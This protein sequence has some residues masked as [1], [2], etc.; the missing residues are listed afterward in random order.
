MAH[1][2]FA[3][4]GASVTGR[5][6]RNVNLHRNGQDGFTIV[7]SERSTVAVVADG[8][9]SSRHSEVGAKLG[10]RLAAEI[11]RH[12]TAEHGEII[13]SAVLRELLAGIGALTAQMGGSFSRTVQDY[14]LFTL[15]GTV[16]TGETAIFFALGDGIVIV[17]G[18]HFP[19][20]PFPG[21]QPPYAAYGLVKDRVD[22]PAELLDF[23]EICRLPLSDLEHFLIG[24]DGVND[25][26]AAENL[27]TPGLPETVGSISQF[28]EDGKYFEPGKSE[29]ME[30][31]LRIISRDWPKHDPEPG[32][33]PDDTTLI[34]GR[35]SP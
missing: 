33:L 35:W 10:A 2:D 21:N 22:I 9:G 25:L 5:D 11:I 20:G 34:A 1:T 31:R 17:N 26:I 15:A 16:L 12:Q 32:L 6:H 8:C 27:K 30:R 23:R 4:A 13:W 29:L 28:W 24:T 14:F 19:L 3:L 18:Q 7:R